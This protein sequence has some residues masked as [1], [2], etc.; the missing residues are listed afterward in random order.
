MKMM[1]IGVLAIIVSIAAN[2]ESRVTAFDELVIFGSSDLDI[3]NNGRSTNGPVW[4]EY[5][6]NDLN[7][8][9]PSPSKFGGTDY[10]WGGARTGFGIDQLFGNPTPT[11]GKQIEDYLAGQ[12]PDASTLIIITGG[13]NDI[14][15]YNS[16]PTAIV[17]NMSDHISEVAAAGGKHFLVPNLVP[18]GFSPGSSAFGRPETLNQK[19]EMLNEQLSPALEDLEIRLGVRIYQDDFFGLIQSVVADPSAFGLENARDSANEN[20][21]KA[22]TY[23]Y[24]DNFHFTTSGHRILADSVSIA[25]PEPSTHLINVIGT[26]IFWMFSRRPRCST[27]PRVEA[28]LWFE[29][30]RQLTHQGNR[31]PRHS[32]SGTAPITS[33]VDRYRHRE[34]CNCESHCL[35]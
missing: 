19:A 34:R 8:P 5:L 10:A 29:S 22:A 7:L 13:W 26:T 1:T 4:A 27:S 20:A 24:W 31:P 3:G 32:Y 33:L 16:S 25:V 17:S 15:I 9:S 30:F 11:V 35:R 14:A 21:T 12:V 18:L 28:S 23:L 2:S 6:A